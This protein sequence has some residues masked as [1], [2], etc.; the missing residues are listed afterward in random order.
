MPFY[1][2]SIPS[3][4][5]SLVI[6]AISYLPCAWSLL[7]G[8]KPKMQKNSAGDVTL[9]SNGKLWDKNGVFELTL[10]NATNLVIIATSC[11]PFLVSG[12]YFDEKK[13]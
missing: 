10:L 9:T 5:R 13:S 12:V 3:V 4:A 7:C 6:I 11:L 1:F 8:K 2:Y